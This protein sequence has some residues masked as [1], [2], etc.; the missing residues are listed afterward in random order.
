MANDEVEIS[1][2]RKRFVESAASLEAIRSKLES[3]SQS[4]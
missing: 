1:L 2:V 4:D 3:L